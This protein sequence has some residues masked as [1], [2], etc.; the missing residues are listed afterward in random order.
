[1][2]YIMALSLTGEETVSEKN[3]RWGIIGAGVI[4][5]KMAEAINLESGCELVAVASKSPEKADAFAREY[6]IAAET[7]QSL[8]DRSDVD[9]IYIATTH[10]FHAENALLAL[11]HGKHLVIEKPFTVNAEQARLLQRT[12]QDNDCFMM[13]AIWTRFLPSMSKLRETLQNGTVGEIKVASINFGGIAPDHYRPRLFD[14]ALAGGVTLDMGIYPL[15]MLC[16]LLGELPK[17]THASCR[18]SDTGVDEIASYQFVFPSGCIATVN[19][20]FNLLMRQEALFFGDRGS[21]EYPEFQQS[22]SFTVKRIEDREIANEEILTATNAD[23]GFV[24]QVR[25]AARCL[26]AGLLESPVIPVAESVDIMA[27]LD[28]IRRQLPLRYDFEEQGD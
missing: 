1:M 27:V 19:T 23:N 20:S 10:N 2:G 22:D 9:V 14:P 24:Y 13:E 5:H 28:D 6:D 8:V 4:A 12:A 26:R 17:E 16:Y 25:E 15:S 3:I 7:Y 11:E 18:F 21:I